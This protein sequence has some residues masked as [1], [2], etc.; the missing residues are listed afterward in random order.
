MELQLPE[1]RMRGMQRW[2][3]VRKGFYQGG[4]GFEGYID[5]TVTPLEEGLLQIGRDLISMLCRRFPFDHNKKEK[6]LNALYNDTFDP[7]AIRFWND[8]F[9]AKLAVLKPIVRSNVNL[10]EIRAKTESVIAPLPA[11]V[12]SRGSDGGI[13]CEYTIVPAPVRPTVTLRE[14]E[15]AKVVGNSG[16]IG[17]PTTRALVEAI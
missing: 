8:A 6:F 12:I 3:Q 15:P 14:S 2:Q 5:Q 10:R 9:G 13:Q 4:T 7:E 1:S 17:H 11:P 16:K